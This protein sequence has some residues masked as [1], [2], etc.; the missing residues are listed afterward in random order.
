MNSDYLSPVLRERGWGWGPPAAPGATRSAAG[1]GGGWRHRT[2][3]T[4]RNDRR[5]TV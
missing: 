2:L 4:E 1:T 3:A 5:C